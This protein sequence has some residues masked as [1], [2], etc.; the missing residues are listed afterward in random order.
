[1]WKTPRLA[2]TLKVLQHS[3]TLGE[4]DSTDTYFN[5]E[6]EVLEA[7]WSLHYCVNEG[8]CLNVIYIY[9]YNINHFTQGSVSISLCCDWQKGGSFSWLCFDSYAEY[10]NHETE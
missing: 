8:V 10:L 5:Q 9:I 3:P 4:N 2:H 1:M 7:W 6:S